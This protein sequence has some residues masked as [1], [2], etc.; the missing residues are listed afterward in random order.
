[1]VVPGV[2][3]DVQH[4]PDSL[5]V[6]L[7]DGAGKSIKDERYVLHK[8]DGSKLEGKD[9][10]RGHCRAEGERRLV[11]ARL[12]SRIP[13]VRRFAPKNDV[14]LLTIGESSGETLLRPGG[15]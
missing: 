14:R 15:T 11:L 2:D 1:V 8:P 9:R 13:L 10:R 5:K 4:K 12:S 3:P 6:K 7:V